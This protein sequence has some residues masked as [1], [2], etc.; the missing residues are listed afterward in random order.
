ME[1]DKII[2]NFW[3]KEVARIRQRSDGRYY[4]SD[5]FGKTLGYYDPKAYGGKGATYDFWGKMIAEGDV[6][7]SLIKKWD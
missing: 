5:F 6:L 3:G 2:R 7:T 1:K 4:I